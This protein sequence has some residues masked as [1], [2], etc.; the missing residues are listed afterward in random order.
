MSECGL[1]NLATCLPEKLYDFLLN[2]LNAPIQP[3]LDFTK[4][5]LTEP[6]NLSLF[7]S[8]WAIIIYVLSLF[9]GLL[10]LYSG[11]NFIISGYD[12]EKRNKAKEWFRNIFIMIV[13]IQAS[14]FLYS[15]IIDINALLTS[16]VINIINENFFLLTADNI[17]NLGLQFIFA[18]FYGLTL[19]FTVLFLTLRY[20]IIAIGV[21]F[22]PIG[23]FFYFIP[24]LKEYGK[25]I[26][27]FL[28]TCIFVTF[29]D[30]L[31]L[32][33]SSKI[34]EIAIFANFKILVMISAFSMANLLMFYLMFFTAIKSALKTGEKVS[35]TV[36]S[37]AKYFA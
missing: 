30:S 14:Y 18:L 9:Y 33:A 19:F 31:I 32:L 11:F 35:V 3:L 29:F 17:V 8:I 24:P 4:S 16:G 2:I 10:M 20:I 34:T 6:V 5:L 22:I 27:N 23:I 12:A 15:L 28:G 1:M 21:V 26:M 36:A 37:V 25:L 13:L 7:S